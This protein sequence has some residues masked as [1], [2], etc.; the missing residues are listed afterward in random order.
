MEARIL[1]RCPLLST[2]LGALADPAAA[3]NTVLRCQGYQ[4]DDHHKLTEEIITLD[5]ENKV[6][7]S[8]QLDGLQSRDVI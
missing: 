2:L 8:I 1:Q 7:V 3:K 5:M 6:V 4:P